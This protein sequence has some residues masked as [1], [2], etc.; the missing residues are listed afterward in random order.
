MRNQERKG[1]AMLNQEVVVQRLKALATIVL[2]H[3]AHSKPRDAAEVP[4]ES[5]AM[6]AACWVAGEPWS[7]HPKCVS[8]AIGAMMRTFNDRCGA[9]VA[10]DARRTRVLVPLIPIILSTRGSDA[11]ERRRGFAAADWVIRRSMPRLLARSSSLAPWGPKIA[12]LA[13][14]VDDYSLNAA[15]SILFEMRQEAW[16]IRD[17]AW[18]SIRKRSAEE[19]AVAAAAVAAAAAAAVAE[20]AVAEAA[21]AALAVE[22]FPAEICT[23]AYKAAKKVALSG[24]G[25]SSKKSAAR[26]VF[27]EFIATNPTH[28]FIGTRDEPD[29]EFQELVR[30]LASMTEDVETRSS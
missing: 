10:A 8:I 24:G 4:P 7:D 25:W 28:S 26:A 13:P 30:L 21:A 18:A 11:L 15:R 27:G 9:G 16:R 20:A 3:G 19:A 14:I 17:D 12:G 23:A 1:I 6:E 5:C 2:R 29:R 22:G